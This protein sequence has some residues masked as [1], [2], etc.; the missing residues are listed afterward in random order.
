MRLKFPHGINKHKPGF[1]ILMYLFI[2]FYNFF[3]WHVTF[4]S[5]VGTPLKLNAFLA[6][7]S[8]SVPCY[9][10]ASFILLLC[11][12]RPMLFFH[13]SLPWERT[14]NRRQETRGVFHRLLL[15]LSSSVHLCGSVYIFVC[16]FSYFLL[17]VLSGS[18]FHWICDT[19]LICIVSN[20]LTDFYLWGL[21]L[22]SGVS[23]LCLD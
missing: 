5:N 10:C 12:H 4:H 20:L 13:A 1:F 9:V 21:H 22:T 23:P 16:V 7:T 8:E 3:L 15:W 14:G 11:S 17:S 19:L 18:L 6:C 2:L